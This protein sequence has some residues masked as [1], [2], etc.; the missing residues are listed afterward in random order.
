MKNTTDTEFKMGLLSVMAGLALALENNTDPK[1][2][3]LGSVLK[4]R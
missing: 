2:N 4:P 3:H 1:L